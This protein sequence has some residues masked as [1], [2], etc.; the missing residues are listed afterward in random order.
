MLS[1]WASGVSKKEE[2][3]E[4]GVDGDDGGSDYPQGCRGVEGPGGNWG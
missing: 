4:G 2:D 1:V 3:E